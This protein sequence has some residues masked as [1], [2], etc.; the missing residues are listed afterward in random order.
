MT[1]LLVV[2]LCVQVFLVVAETVLSLWFVNRLTR[3]ERAVVAVLE[4][5]MLSNGATQ[6]PPELRGLL[7]P[8]EG[9][10]RV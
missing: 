1:T 3:T 2:V 6:V 4:Y 9:A 8:M 5:V 7:P 10:H